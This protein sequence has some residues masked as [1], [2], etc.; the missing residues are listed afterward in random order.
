MSLV[1][2]LLVVDEIRGGGRNADRVSFDCSLVESGVVFHH[3]M[4]VIIAT[5]FSLYCHITSFIISLLPY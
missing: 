5:P 2:S 1:S 3:T 4:A